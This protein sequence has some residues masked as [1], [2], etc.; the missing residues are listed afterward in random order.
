M[1]D[2]RRSRRGEGAA[3][4]RPLR[5]AIIG[6]GEISPRFLK[7]GAVSTRAEFV[8]VSGRRMESAQARAAEFGIGASFD[9]YRQMFDVV[10]P[11]AVVIATPSL[12]HAEQ[13]I[14]AMNRG[15]HVL[16]EKPMALSYADCLAMVET[17]ERTGTVLLCL[18]FDDY[19]GTAAVRRY[20]ATDILGTFTGAEAK[21]V[22][23]GHA[24]ADWFYDRDVAGGVM[25]DTMV[26]P[27]S[28]LVSLLGPARRVTGFANTLI[29]HRLVQGRAIDSTIDDNVSLIL[30]WPGGQQAMLRAFWATSSWR[31]DYTLYGRKATIFAGLFNSDELVVSSPGRPLE[32][33]GPLTHNGFA[34]CYRIPI[35]KPDVAQEGL[36]EHFID[37][38]LGLAQPSCGSRRQLHVHEILFKGYEAARSGMAQTLETSF[39]PRPA[40]DPALFDTR[41]K[42]I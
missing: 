30:E 5:L 9:D 22:F 13:A 23:S 41:S 6:T 27:V 8:A 20:L 11:D 26:Y 12:V 7:Q 17:S 37:C 31:S 14:E 35:S 36:L 34:D 10:R 38:V 25:L 39:E 2:K 28:R 4:D 21:I 16:C 33:E 1:D 42:P 19:P 18:P 40:I 15:I 24:K 3:A 29:P 32:G